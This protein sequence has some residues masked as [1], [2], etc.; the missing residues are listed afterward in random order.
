MNT[1]IPIPPRPAHQRGLSLVELMVALT[2][3]LVLAG[4]A[5][6][7]Y[8]GSRQTYR[9]SDTLARHQENLRLVFEQLGHDLRVGGFLGCPGTAGS[10]ALPSCDVIPTPTSCSAL[11][12]PND[13]LVK[14]GEAI[15]GYEAISK[16]AWHLPPDGSITAPL[17]GRDILVVR[18]VYG[19]P[20]RLVQPQGDVAGADPLVV[21]AG[22][23]RKPDDVGDVVLISDCQASAAVFQ[24]TDIVSGPVD[25]IKHDVSGP[26]TLGQ[27]GNGTPKLARR[28]DYGE[29]Q[30][31]STQVYYVRNNAA[32][33]P[34]LYLLDGATAAGG[35]QEL[36]EGVQDLQV[37]YS[38]TPGSYQTAA[39]VG[40]WDQVVSVRVAV[41]LRSLEDNLTTTEQ[42]FNWYKNPGDLAPSP[43]KPS[44]FGWDPRRLYQPFEI[45]F[46][47]RNRTH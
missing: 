11:N 27:P 10:A 1:S 17:G 44:D 40:N 32:G 18:G 3:S 45:T 38:T 2:L 43:V 25:T 34:A 5:L 14:F 28:F 7:V 23:F 16:S 29:L 41:L 9:T 13:F 26:L 6:T 36:V 4:A 35:P 47:L 39:T 12:N 31:L 22:I 37:F 33:Q 20:V 24:I 21:T 15:S 19:P 30:R 8:L 42:R 46:A